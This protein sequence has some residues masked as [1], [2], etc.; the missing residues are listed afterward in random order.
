MR[1]FEETFNEAWVRETL[2]TALP[3]GVVDHRAPE[4]LRAVHGAP[5]TH[6]GIREAFW[7]PL[8]LFVRQYS[9]EYEKLRDQLVERVED[10]FAEDDRPYVGEW[11]AQQGS[12]Q[13]DRREKSYWSDLLCRADR[14]S[15]LPDHKV[16]GGR[17]PTSRRS[18]RRSW[19]HAMGR[20]TEKW[21]IPNKV[22]AAWLTFKAPSDWVRAIRHIERCIGGA[23]PLLIPYDLSRYGPVAEPL[24]R[25][26][27][28]AMTR[29]L[30]FVDNLRVARLDDPKE[31][32]HY[33]WQKRGGCCGSENRQITVLGR[34]FLIGC[35]YGH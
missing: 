31:K 11:L 10:V 23:F 14:D 24:L 30:D 8:G 13:W 32:S 26:E 25:A 7:E 2:L 35:N 4:V 20:Y 15:Q 12:I 21:R 1:P 17:G 6:E 29:D 16:I 33:R 28:E 5:K 3:A 34:R 27:I 22:E 18:H 19:W 9:P